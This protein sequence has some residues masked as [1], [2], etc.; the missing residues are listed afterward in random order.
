M[1]FEARRR[2]EQR[3]L[4]AVF[5]S[6]LCRPTEEVSAGHLTYIPFKVTLPG[7]VST[8]SEMVFKYLQIFSASSD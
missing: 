6:H 2:T 5:W 4:S 8:V 3:W 7:D 1:I